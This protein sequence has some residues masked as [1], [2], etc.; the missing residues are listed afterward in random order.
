MIIKTLK[1]RSFGGLLDYLFDAQDKP[2]PEIEARGSPDDRGADDE[3]PQTA[4]RGGETGTDK[5][6]QRGNLLITNMGGNCKEELLEHFESLAALRPDVEVNVLHAILSIPEDD[7]LSRA[8]K[9]RLVL[10]FAELKGLDRTM[11]AAVEHEEHGHTEIHVISSTVNLNGRVPSDSF[12]YDRGE[13][14]ARRLEKESKQ[15]EQRRD[16]TR[17]DA[18]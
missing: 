6:T 4:E 1:G 7:V 11:Y 12:D 17:P 18:G 14:I 3:P 5:R 8:K 16:V 13:A 2:P 9:V 15:V 10:R